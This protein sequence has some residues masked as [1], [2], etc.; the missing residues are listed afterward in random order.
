MKNERKRML[1]IPLH[2]SKAMRR[3]GACVLLFFILHTSW[4]ATGVRAQTGNVGIGTV[5]P[6]NSALL[7][8]TSTSKGLLI[9]RMTEAQRIAIAAPATGLLV[10]ETNTSTALSNPYGGQ[11]ATFWFFNGTIWQPFLG[12]GW[13]L[14]GNSG[15]SAA[16]NFI[17]TIDSV[18]WIIRT[19]NLEHVRVYAA[20][21]VGL[22]NTNNTAEELRFYEPSGSGATYTGFKAGAQTTSVTYTLPLAD[23]TASNYVL[24]T[25]GFANLSWRGV[26]VS[27]GAGT[28]TLWHRGTGSFSLVGVGSGC[29]ASGAYSISDG[30][31]NLSS[32]AGSVTWGEDNVASGYASVVSGGLGDTASGNYSTIGGGTG[33]N[34]SGTYSSVCAGQSNT[35]CGLYAVVVGGANNTA[36][37]NYATVLGGHDNSVSGNYSLAFGI[38]CNVTTDNTIVYYNSTATTKVGI[39]TVTPAEVLDVVGNVRFSGALMPNGLAGTSGYVLASTGSTAPVWTAPSN[40]YWST[41]GNTGTSPATNYL[42]TS[43]AQPIVFRTNATERMRVLSTGQVAVNT[44]TTTHQ[45]ASLYTGTTDETA[46]IFGNATGSTTSQSIGVWGAATATSGGNTGTIGVLATGNGNTGSGSTNVALQLNDGEFAMGRTTEAPGTGTAVEGA[47]AGTAYSAQG[48][49]GVIELTLGGGNLATAAPTAG[50][51]QNLGTLTI[52]NRYTG[53]SSIVLVNIE[54]KI[55]DGVAPDSKQAEYFVDVDNRTAGSFD[56]RVG[57]IPTTTSA[58][59]YT[60]SDKIRIGYI[61][62]NPGR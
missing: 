3:A 1:R 32:G 24:C 56:I 44:T 49:S 62:I 51:Y 6:D 10:Y 30:L 14:L 61:V 54:Q 8:L 20:G 39:G 48:P 11:A 36:C 40:L 28:D 4:L 31:N 2:E 26:G 60:T 25:D 58:S 55:D 29:A 45:L 41:L 23:G 42:G 18:D 38:G 15:T 21:N 5:S 46:A 12:A 19:N 57:M 35:A 27:G 43:D 50:V 13:L 7:D 33:N 53:A 17:G 9:P 59:N 47:T 16:T 52:N 37:G 22:T 34:A